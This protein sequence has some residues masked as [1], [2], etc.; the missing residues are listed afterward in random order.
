MA[1]ADG[2]PSGDGED[3]DDKEAGAD[4]LGPALAARLF[5]GDSH[6][7][8]LW[9]LPKRRVRAGVWKRGGAGWWCLELTLSVCVV[10]MCV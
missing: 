9:S 1:V 5:V 6:R 4:L 10:W 3:D 8:P 2:P 7:R